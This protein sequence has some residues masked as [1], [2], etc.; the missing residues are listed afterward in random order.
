MNTLNSDEFNQVKIV[1]VK[2]I[3]DLPKYWMHQ[4]TAETAQEAIKKY[5]NIT[6]RIP[7]VIYRYQKSNG[8]TDFYIPIPGQDE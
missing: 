1:E 8:E 6:K 3:K 4:Y 5:V 7:E 2:E